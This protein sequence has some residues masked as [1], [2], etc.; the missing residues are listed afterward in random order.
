M[1]IYLLARLLP[2]QRVRMATHPLF[3]RL[4]TLSPKKNVLSLLKIKRSG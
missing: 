3:T 4:K 2:D 1:F